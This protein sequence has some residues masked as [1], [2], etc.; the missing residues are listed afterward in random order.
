MLIRKIRPDRQQP[1]PKV[2]LLNSPLQMDRFLQ[3]GSRRRDAGQVVAVIRD[4]PNTFATLPASRRRTS[5]P[6]WR[7]PG[8]FGAERF[9]RRDV[10]PGAT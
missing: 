7:A 9:S 2:S 10:G 3:F 5:C 1:Q 8:P 4:L 6:V